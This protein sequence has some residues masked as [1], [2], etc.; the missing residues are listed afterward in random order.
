[1]LMQQ[2]KHR[3]ARSSRRILVVEQDHS[4]R[5]ALVRALTL[6]SYDVLSAAASHQAMRFLSDNQIDLVILDLSQASEGGWNVLRWLADSDPLLPVIAITS[7]VKQAGHALA[8][9]ANALMEKPLEMPAL[10][11]TI[12]SLITEDEARHSLRM[13]HKNVQASCESRT[14]D[15]EPALIKTGHESRSL[16]E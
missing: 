15:S 10:L 12:S 11:A 2:I 13:K 9:R 5:E 16:E 8:D 1:M 7:Q 3:T 6:Q 4:V 14:T